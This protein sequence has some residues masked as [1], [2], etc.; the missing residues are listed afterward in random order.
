MHIIL[1]QYVN[2][3]RRRH[4]DVVEVVRYRHG[5]PADICAMLWRHHGAPETGQV[6][7]TCDHESIGRQNGSVIDRLHA[8]NFFDFARRR[9]MTE[10]GGSFTP[11]VGRSDVTWAYGDSDVRSRE[12]GADD[13]TAQSG[14]RVG[15]Q[16]HRLVVYAETDLGRWRCERR[17]VKKMWWRRN[18]LWLLSLITV[19]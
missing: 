7:V 5:A 15:S 16:S 2:Y 12:T 6:V 8:A 19:V 17:R 10:G 14:R 18:R 3:N 11:E 9:W 4:L 1:T 13:D